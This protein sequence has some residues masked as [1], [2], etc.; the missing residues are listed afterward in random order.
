MSTIDLI[1]LG[2]LL[3]EAQNAYEVVRFIREKEV[4]RV[5]KISEP[6][7]FKSCRRLAEGGYL[8]GQTIRSEGVPDK[9]VYAVN[10]KGEQYFS[11]LMK[12]FAANFK[13]FYLDFNTVL[14][15]ID[16]LKEEDALNSL[17]TLQEQLHEAYLWVSKH[18]EEVRSFL[19]FGPRQ[20]VK[21]YT[22]T[23][24]ALKQ[25]IDEAVEDYSHK[26]TR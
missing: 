22:M 9:V 24:G 1:V 15:N 20:I 19:P 26:N 18:D 16:Q 7:V 14:W 6:A 4:H 8:D 13:P 3:R 10:A 17:R 2:I 25:W 5:L 11:E 23:I 21:Q 12:H